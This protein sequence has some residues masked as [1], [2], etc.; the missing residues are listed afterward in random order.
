MTGD[1]IGSVT[2]R[3]LCHR[4]APSMS[5]ASYRCAGT[6]RRPARKMI[7][8]CPTPHRPRNTSPH[9]E[10]DGSKNQSGG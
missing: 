3:N 1:I 2:Y 10:V 7:I 9:F 4:P 8:V 5:A 6:S